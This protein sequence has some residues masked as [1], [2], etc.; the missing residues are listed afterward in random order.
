MADN[1]FTKSRLGDRLERMD[2]EINGWRL[3]TRKKLLLRLLQ[4]GLTDKLRLLQTDK[5]LVKSLG[6]RLRK[7]Q[8]DIEAIGFS[9]ARKGIFIERGVGRGR[10]VGSS[11]AKANEQPWLSVVLPPSIE[12]LA[13]LLENEYA[14]IA[15]AEL[16]F[17]IPGVI[18]SKVN[19][20]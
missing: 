4:L 1:A 2:Q 9:F 20:S 12:D 3:L 13:D 6:S 15:A 8:G 5:K 11:K 18:S 14:D 7:K 17:N 10:P 19:K 16:N